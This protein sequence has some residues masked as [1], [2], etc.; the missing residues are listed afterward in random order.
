MAARAINCTP[1][2]WLSSHVQLFVGFALSG[3]PHVHGDLM[4]H[5]KWVGYSFP[6]FIYHAALIT[7]E[8]FL[9]SIGAR[10]GIWE[11]LFTRAI[12]Y[13]W[14]YTW[15]IYATPWLNDWHLQAGMGSHRVF[16][17]SMVMRLLEWIDTT[18][19]VDVLSWVASQCAL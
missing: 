1:G 11:S 2:S 10:L 3:L 18:Y 12:G 17:F 13:L 6:F 8:D 14:T 15:L 9:I 7:L 5:P 19:G 4:L 16:R